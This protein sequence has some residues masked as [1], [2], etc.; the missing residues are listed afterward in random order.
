[1][2]VNR[3]TILPGGLD[4]EVQL[5]EPV[6]DMLH[7]LQLLCLKLSS[8]GDRSFA[9]AGPCA[10]WNKLPP[11]YHRFVTSILLLLSNANLRHFYTMKYNTM[12]YNII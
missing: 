10:A 3:S 8:F 6:S 2:L 5:S 7:P 4:R 11:R 9:A 12:I 1:M